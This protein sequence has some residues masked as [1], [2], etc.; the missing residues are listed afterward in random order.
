MHILDFDQEKH[1]KALMAKG[2]DD[3]FNDGFNNGLTKERFMII[4]HMS[5][6][7][8]SADEISY[9]SG[10]PLEDVRE[11]QEKINKQSFA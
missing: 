9:L 10:I 4:Q 8:K 1:D 11:I 5:V 6:L 2:F 3:G 7:G